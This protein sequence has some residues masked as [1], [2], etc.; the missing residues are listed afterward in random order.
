VNEHPFA[1]LQAS[2]RAQ[3]VPRRQEGERLRAA[4]SN[5]SAGGFGATYSMRDVTKLPMAS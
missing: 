4:S 3:S 2:E 5:V 1:R